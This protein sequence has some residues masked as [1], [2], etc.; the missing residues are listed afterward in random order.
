MYTP[1]ARPNFSDYK[2]KTLELKPWFWW[3]VEQ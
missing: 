2:H 3:L 1:M